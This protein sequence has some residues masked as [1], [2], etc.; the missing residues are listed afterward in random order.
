MF[1]EHAGIANG[2][3]AVVVGIEIGVEIWSMERWEEEQRRIMEH[4]MKKDELEMMRDLDNS[5]AEQ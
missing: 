3:D 4:S 1:K 2:T 5:P